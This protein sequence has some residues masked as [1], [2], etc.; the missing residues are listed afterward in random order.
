MR[1]R[2]ASPCT[3]TPTARRI[4]DR[5]RRASTPWPRISTAASPRYSS[6]SPTSAP[7]HATP[8][9]AGAGRGKA[10]RRAAAPDASEHFEVGRAAAV[11]PDPATR[12]A[13]GLALDARGTA[14]LAHEL[15]GT[16]AGGARRLR[17]VARLAPHPATLPGRRPD[18]VLVADLELAFAAV[19]HP[20][21]ALVVGP[22]A[23]VDARRL[24]AL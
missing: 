23:A 17:V 16:A 20:D 19:R 22:G 9:A 13:P 21:P 10:P 5:P 4:S 11:D 12:P 14:D 7:R 8:E 3:P 1:A 24:A 6:T 2:R 15:R 18:L